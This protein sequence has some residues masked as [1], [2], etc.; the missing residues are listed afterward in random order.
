MYKLVK[1]M[2]T[3]DSGKLEDTKFY[4]VASNEQ[5]ENILLKDVLLFILQVTR[6]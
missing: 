5:N 3:D 2:M 1:F 4:T 6:F